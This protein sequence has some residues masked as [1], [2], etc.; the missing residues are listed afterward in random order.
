MKNPVSDSPTPADT[1]TITP[2]TNINILRTVRGGHGTKTVV[3]DGRRK[4]MEVDYRFDS[5]I[6]YWW[7]GDVRYGF[8]I[9]RN[10][11]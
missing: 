10:K 5:G 6:K 8:R 11:S 9:V 2:W 4:S 1:S 7:D 3:F